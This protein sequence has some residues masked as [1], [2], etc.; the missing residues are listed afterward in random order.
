MAPKSGGQTDALGIGATQV[1][2]EPALGNKGLYHGAD[3][4]SQDKGPAR[5]PEKTGGCLGR[6]T[7]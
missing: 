5:L 2:R 3:E 7:I 4:I 6:F 1:G